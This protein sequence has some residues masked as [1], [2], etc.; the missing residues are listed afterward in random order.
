MNS[1]IQIKKVSPTTQDFS[2]FIFQSPYSR[3]INVGFIK[4]SNKPTF[5]PGRLNYGVPRMLDTHE[6]TV[7]ILQT[8]VAKKILKKYIPEKIST[9]VIMREAVACN[10][11]VA[12]ARSGI[13]NHYG[14][15]FIGATHIKGAGP[16]RTDYRYENTE[17]LT[18]NGLWIVADSVCMGR[19]FLP[20]FTSLFAQGF[21]PKE[22]L[23]ILPLATRRGIEVFAPLLKKHGIHATFVAMG[24]LFG[25][26]DNLYNLPWGHPDTEPLDTRDQDVFVRMYND[27]LCVGGDFGNYY[28]A[29]PLAKEF[30]NDQLKELRITPHI[31]SA[32]EVFRIYTKEELLMR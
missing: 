7:Q 5:I 4:K 1:S 32:K 17:G 23:F 20:T 27:K 16:I 8:A 28:F 10:L 31:P 12:L 3:A 6:A 30:Y 9:L 15:A 2:I 18:K 25:V 29:P 24:A 14:D 21:I 26:G 19:S 22:I 11:P 13:T